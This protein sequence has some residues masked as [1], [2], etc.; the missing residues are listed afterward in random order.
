MRRRGDHNA[1]V[2]PEKE[3]KEKG[4]AQKPSLTLES[5]RE[6]PLK[7]KKRLRG[8]EHGKGLG[9]CPPPYPQTSPFAA[10][11][12]KNILEHHWEKEGKIECQSPSEGITNLNRLA[13]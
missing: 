2:D 3:K 6:T 1:G 7:K 9:K 8:E 10:H 12:T 4:R 5:L 11:I 13:S